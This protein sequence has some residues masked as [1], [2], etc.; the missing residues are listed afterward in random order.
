MRWIDWN[1]AIR[2]TRVCAPTAAYPDYNLLI[3]QG[4]HEGSS[5]TRWA[6]PLLWQGKGSISCLFYIDFN[7]HDQVREWMFKQQVP[8]H[9]LVFLNAWMPEC[10]WTATFF[11]FISDI[12]PPPT[13]ESGGGS[14]SKFC[15]NSPGQSLMDCP[16]WRTFWKWL[17][18]LSTMVIQCKTLQG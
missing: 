9:F 13:A 11:I 1:K 16:P 8:R 10:K 3:M 5:L 2:S 14:P 12:T 18:V 7:T 17:M 15:W 4:K 6:P